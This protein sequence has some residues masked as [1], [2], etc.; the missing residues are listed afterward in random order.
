LGGVTNP[1][2]EK[3][4]VAF[5]DHEGRTRGADYVSWVRLNGGE[6]GVGAIENQQKEEGERPPNVGRK[7]NPPTRQVRGRYFCQSMTAEYPYSGRRE[8]LVGLEG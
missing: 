8:E 2:K 7:F 4:G 6:N 1:K 5:R 3:P